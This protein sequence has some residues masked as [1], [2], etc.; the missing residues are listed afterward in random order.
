MYNFYKTPAWG[1]TGWIILLIL[2]SFRAYSQSKTD[3]L[4]QNRFDLTASEFEFPQTDF[5]IIGFGAYHGSS[6]T[7]TT[8]FY[9]LKSLT[10][11]GAIKY[12]LPETDFSLAHFFNAYLETGDTLLLKDLVVHY[13]VRVPQEQSIETYEKWKSLKELHDHLPESDRLSIVGIDLMVTYKY[14]AKHLLEIL[15]LGNIQHESLQKIVDMVKMDTTDFSPYYHS[16]SKKVLKN[17]VEAYKET[18]QVFEAGIGDKFAFEH[19][20]DNLGRTFTDPDFSTDREAIIFNNYL[21]L[22]S[23]YDFEN[24]PQFLRFGFF[25]LE[26]Q[27][28]GGSPSF[29][30]RL[31]ENQVYP[32]DKVLSIIG[33]LTASRVLWDI[34]YDQEGN[35][36]SYT[37]E[38]GFGIGDYEQEYFLG[39]DQLKKTKLSD[40]TLF[41]LNQ[42]NTPYADGVPDLMEIVMENEKS[43]G[44]E[45]RGK[46]TTE[47]LDYAV[48]I[49]NSPASVP[50]QEKD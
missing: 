12:Y 20:V 23:R 47:F 6:K 18:P 14:T 2:V 13:G 26:K 21:H 3:Y 32:R 19:I 4:E 17:F 25:H 43:N 16:Y 41:R 36:K 38:G 40:F 37:T 42:N 39:I 49:S 1:R 45:V 33:Y 31:I 44:E 27:R 34:V 28:E 24:K 48:L 8:E 35:Y 10:G 29:F 7:E 15:D 50:I 11:S 9:L 5:N 46:S 30:T 22:G